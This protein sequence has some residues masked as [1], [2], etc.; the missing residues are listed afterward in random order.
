VILEIPREMTPARPDGEVARILSLDQAAESDARLRRAHA[1]GRE[2]A[3]GREAAR[4]S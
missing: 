3:R 2:N 1:Q 4:Q